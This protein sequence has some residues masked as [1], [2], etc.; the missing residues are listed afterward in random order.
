MGVLLLGCMVGEV[1]T[2]TEG[3]TPGCTMSS[4]QD[5]RR[6]REVLETYNGRVF[7]TA[8]NHLGWD[9]ELAEGTPVY[10]LGCGI[11]RV[12][13]S[14][15]GYGTLVVVIEHRLDR[16]IRLPNGNGEYVFVD[17]FLSIYGHLRPT[18]EFGGRGIAHALHVGDLVAPSTLIG[19]VENGQY[20]GDGAEHLHLGVRLQ[21]ASEAISS[22]PLAW[23]RGYD[24]TAHAFRA[25][26]T[27]PRDAISV[28]R[29][30]ITPQDHIDAAVPASDHIPSVGIDAPVAV[31]PIVH[32]DGGGEA[33]S[34]IDAV[35]VDDRS[36]I[37][38]ALGV[39]S[40]GRNDA[41]DSL[42]ADINGTD[43]ASITDV[44]RASIDVGRIP[45]ASYEVRLSA[46][47]SPNG[48]YRLRDQDWNPVRCVNTGSVDFELA[49]DGY[50]RCMAPRMAIFDVTF[51]S[52]D[53]VTVRERGTIT[54][55]PTR[56]TPLVGVDWIL[57]DMVAN[58]VVFAGPSNGLRCAQFGVRDFWQF[59]N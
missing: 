10:P 32:P 38:D 17:R 1:E 47:L 48:P 46:A 52:P 36:V 8:G 11:V 16:L 5:P 41:S 18:S 51:V 7:L 59:P 26:Y 28:L 9:I 33:A 24:T 58:Q 2:S 31:L 34:A 4:I 55:A 27:D 21:S 3:I 30:A 14:A 12:A 57:T 29:N 25:V 40:D 50:L 23:F 56:C 54:G 6:D 19:Y 35:T 39:F 20:N 15:Q 37:R 49:G 53:S 43:T 22:D 44:V 42:F 45:L 13:R